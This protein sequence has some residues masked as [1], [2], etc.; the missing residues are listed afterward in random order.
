M[1]EVSTLGEAP[2]KVTVTGTPV[3]S[4]LKSTVTVNLPLLYVP[5]ESDGTGKRAGQT[6]PALT[7]P[8]MES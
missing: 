8:V 4:S 3:A 2:E 5:S 1:M 6:N 7:A